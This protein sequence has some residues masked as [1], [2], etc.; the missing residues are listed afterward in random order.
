MRWRVGFRAKAALALAIACGCGGGTMSV[1]S[2]DASTGASATGPDG[3]VD[4][5]PEASSASCVIDG[6]ALGAFEADLDGSDASS[7]CITCIL[8]TCNPQ[9]TACAADCT[10]NGQLLGFL[11]CSAD[12]G[13]AIACGEPLA[14]ADAATV[15]ALTDCVGGVFAGGTGLGCLLQCGVGRTGTDAG[16]PQDAGASQDGNAPEDASPMADAAIDAAD[17]PVG[18]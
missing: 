3:A 2:P 4:G 17:A 15:Q 13:S 6:A 8:Q 16:A 10:C 1:V 12:G 9:L 11:A 7:A 18:D 14:M 5:G